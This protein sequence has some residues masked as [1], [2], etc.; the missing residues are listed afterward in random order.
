MWDRAM[1][2]DLLIVDDQAGVR[3][4]LSEAFS[5]EGYTVE[6]ASNGAEAVKK[7]SARPPSL[8]LL[9]FKMPGMSGFET[10]EELRRIAPDAPVIVITAFN[11][12]DIVD[13]A[14]KRGA[15]C[16]INKPF[17]LHEILTLVK[18]LLAEEESGR[19]IQI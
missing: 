9:D 3:R 1:I 17:D 19:Q 18:G 6:T 10:L 15:Q 14:K 12:P 16:C 5:G 13:E 8:I 2:Y 7:A 4:F 11:D